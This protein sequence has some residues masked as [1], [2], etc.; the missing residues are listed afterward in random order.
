MKSPVLIKISKIQCTLLV[1]QKRD[2]QFK[3]FKIC[4]NT[5]IHV[6]V[7]WVRVT[8]VGEKVIKSNNF[9]PADFHGKR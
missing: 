5:C 7:F 8:T 3:V 4:N 1:N 2:S 9:I 6:H